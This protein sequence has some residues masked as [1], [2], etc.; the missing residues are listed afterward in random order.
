VD[1]VS[2]AEGETLGSGV[3]E[4]LLRFDFVLG[5]GLADGVGEAFFCF[6][7]AVGDGV[8]VAF[9]AEPFLCLR[10]GTGVGVAR[11]FLVFVPSDSSAETA[12]SI[13]PK[14]IA[15]IKSHFINSNQCTRGCSVRCPQR[16]IQRAL[17]RTQ[18]R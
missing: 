15:K 8:G 17:I 16:T 2:V 1:G 13:D 6:G 9:F 14:R 12:R 3:G 18:M 10:V 5:V 4:A 11:I 7:E